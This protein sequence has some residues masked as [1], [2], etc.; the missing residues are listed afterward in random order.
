MNL[1]HYL[2][3]LCITTY[4][5]MRSTIYNEQHRTYRQRLYIPYDEEAKASHQ[6]YTSNIISL[7]IRTTGVTI[8]MDLFIIMLILSDSLEL[9]YNLD[10]FIQPIG[11]V[12]VFLYV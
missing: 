9:Y 3:L 8:Y 10:L 1:L 12:Y 4:P 5:G 7:F 2:Y 6:D 11:I